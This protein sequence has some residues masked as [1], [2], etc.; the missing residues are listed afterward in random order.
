MPNKKISQ[1]P[2]LNNPTG[3]VLLPAVVSGTNYSVAFSA[4]TTNVDTKHWESNIEK[5]IKSDNTLVISGNY[6]LSGTNL[7][8]NSDNLNITISGIDFNKYAQIFIG[9][10]LLLINSN[11][12]NNGFI[13]VGGGIIMSGSSTITGT[14]IL[15]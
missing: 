14:G 13:S 7:T 4:L 15:I 12:V 5:T 1:F 8:L 6:V 3:N 2:L 11:I 10:Y 9:G